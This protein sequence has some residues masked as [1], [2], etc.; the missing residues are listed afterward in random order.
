MSMY[1]K[2]YKHLS[3]VDAITD[4]T[5]ARVYPVK[6]PQVTTAAFPAVTYQRVSADRVYSF[7]AYCNLENPKMQI[8]SWATSF[9]DVKVLADKVRLA[10][11]S[12]TAFASILISDQDLYEDEIEV[13]RVSQDFSIWNHD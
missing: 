6:L 11:D 4:I 7:T 2:L 1:N 3:T 13:Y 9:E 5:S 8:D 10:M 12:A